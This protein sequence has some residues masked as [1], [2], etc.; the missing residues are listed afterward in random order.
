M[1]R[2]KNP[3]KWHSYR[4]FPR[5]AW[6]EGVLIKTWGDNGF[7]DIPRASSAD[8]AV[9]FAKLRL[10]AEH[11]RGSHVRYWGHDVHIKFFTEA[12]ILLGPA[13]VPQEHWLDRVAS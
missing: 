6:R 7:V 12:T 9:R 2:I 8:Q 5:S 10:K 1:P 11:N 3:E 13:V 4:V